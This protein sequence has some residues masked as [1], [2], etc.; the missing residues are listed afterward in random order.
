MTFCYIINKLH[1]NDS[2]ADSSSSEETNLSSLGVGGKKIND[3]D[4][5]DENLGRFSLLSE[6]RRR[7]VNGEGLLGVDRSTLVDRL[8]K[9]GKGKRAFVVSYVGGSSNY[10]AFIGLRDNETRRESHRAKRGREKKYGL[11]SVLTSPMT[12]MMRPSVSG[13]TGMLMGAPVS[14]TGWPR[15]RPSVPSI[16]IV[17]TVFS[18]KCWATSRMRRGSKSLTSSALF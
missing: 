8:Q 1:N 2:F 3:L 9:K 4:S 13:P 15:T 11:C 5:R 7:S 18:P 14:S 6:N 12:F 10:A 17:R 16:A